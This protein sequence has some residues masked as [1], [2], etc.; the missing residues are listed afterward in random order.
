[1]LVVSSMSVCIY[2]TNPK[3]QWYQPLTRYNNS[4]C[5]Q[6]QLFMFD[7]PSK[8]HRNH[9]YSLR[10]FEWPYVGAHGAASSPGIVAHVRDGIWYNSRG[11]THGK[12]YSPG[13]SN[14][15][16]N[17]ETVKTTFWLTTAYTSRTADLCRRRSRHPNRYQKEE[18]E[19]WQ[20][21]EITIRMA[22]G[23]CWKLPKW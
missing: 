2:T 19:T 10:F 17:P 7:N 16:Q 13:A 21:K 20:K 4:F 3:P 11:R 8:P 1:M 22:I 23:R 12:N 15:A 14:R 18:E 6:L 5:N 9:V